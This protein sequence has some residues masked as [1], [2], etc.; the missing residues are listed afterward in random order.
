MSLELESLVT[1]ECPHCHALLEAQGDAIPEWL[2]CPLC[3]RACVPPEV[4][5]RKIESLGD[6]ILF[7]NESTD[8]I[9]PEAP[10]RPQSILADPIA[11]PRIRAMAPPPSP[12]P[13]RS[14]NLRTALGLGFF[15]F[16]FVAVFSLLES[17]TGQAALSGFA[18]L[19]CLALLFLVGRSHPDE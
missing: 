9:K 14:F 15:I 5:P 8:A 17:H 7:I 6:G 18:S 4:L 11:P 3:E 13:E 1:F 2:R 12:K 16:L 10:A 19:I